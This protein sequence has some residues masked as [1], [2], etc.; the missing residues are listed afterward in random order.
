LHQYIKSTTEDISSEII[1]KLAKDIA[2][3]MNMVHSNGIVH[4]DLKSSNILLEEENN[5][6]SAVICDFGLARISSESNV[7]FL[8]SFF[9]FFSLF[10]SNNLIFK[11]K[12]LLNQKIIDLKGFSP[13][14]TAPEVFGRMMT[15]VT[16]VSVEDEMKGDVYS[17]A[18]IIWELMTRKIPWAHCKLF[19][20][21]N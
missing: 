5:K 4:R 12:K 8:F 11:K 2:S 9:L 3:G 10:F 20:L 15:N 1:L 17:Y 14:Y 21:S 13:R 19:F 18:V 16:V 7:I 6:L